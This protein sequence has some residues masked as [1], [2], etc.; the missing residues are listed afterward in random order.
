MV[1][2]KSKVSLPTTKPV[3]RKV[4][5]CIAEPP[6]SDPINGKLV[7]P[8]QWRIFCNRIVDNKKEHFSKS[9]SKKN[10]NSHEIQALR[11][12]WTSLGPDFVVG[13]I[14]FDFF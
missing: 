4:Q 13:K 2:E 14:I 6:P 1:Q 7:L 3:P 8:N 11:N 5:K 12:F 9:F 10:M